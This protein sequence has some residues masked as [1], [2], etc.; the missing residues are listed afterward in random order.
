MTAF[1]FGA[2]SGIATRDGKANDDDPGFRPVRPA[3]PKARATRALIG[4]TKQR[5]FCT[6]RSPIMPRLAAAKGLIESI[7]V[8][9]AAGKLTSRWRKPRSIRVRLMAAICKPSHVRVVQVNMTLHARNLPRLS[10]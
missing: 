10:R 6:N 8:V 9:K 2:S 7:V 5:M 3:R 4:D 1:A